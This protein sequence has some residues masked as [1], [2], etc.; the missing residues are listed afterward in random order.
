MA[1]AK[2]A[3]AAKKWIDVKAAEFNLRKP[4]VTDD[5]EKRRGEDI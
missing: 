2:T 5:G 3:R 1:Q 4:N